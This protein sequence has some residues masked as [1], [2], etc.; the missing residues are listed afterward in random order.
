[1]KTITTPINLAAI[2][3]TLQIEQEEAE[4]FFQDFIKELVSSH[5]TITQHYEALCHADT[6]AI[7]Q[8]T[9]AQLE[10]AVHKLKGSTCYGQVPILH[11]HCCQLD[12]CLQQQIAEKQPDVSALTPH[13]QPMMTAITE[14]F[15][16]QS[17][18][19]LNHHATDTSDPTNTTDITNLA[20]FLTQW[21]NAYRFEVVKLSLFQPE[22]TAQWSMAQKQQFCRLFYHARGH[23]YKFLWLLG[24]VAPDEN[25]K[26]KVLENID[27]EFGGTGLS[28]ERMYQIFA[29]ALGADVN[30]EFL[31]EPN[32][33]PY[34]QQY[35]L[36]HL[37]WLDQQN[38]EGKWAGFSAY[39]RLD[40]IDYHHLEL[41]VKS[42]GITGCLTTIII[43]YGRHAQLTHFRAHQTKEIVLD[44]RHNILLFLVF[45]CS[46]FG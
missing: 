16:I 41:L 27:E 32:Y 2:C 30:D 36:G 44:L 40:N 29:E 31:T 46:I 35:N 11:H 5:L 37:T 39:E 15:A 14:I 8:T 23:F 22:Q 10:S 18:T 19:A 4:A 6:D 21:D 17:P 13:Y 28:H 20:D 42:F 3:Q 12:Q 25:A 43:P 9:L 33:L 7:R 26:A 45:F 38:W 1:M 34:L 24:N